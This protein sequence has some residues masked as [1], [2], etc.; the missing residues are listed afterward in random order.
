M[1]GKEELQRASAVG[2]VNILGKAVAAGENSGLKKAFLLISDKS[3]ITG[4][5]ISWLTLAA[6]EAGNG[7]AQEILEGW[8]K[9]LMP[10]W[11]PL[12]KAAVLNCCLARGDREAFWK[13]LDAGLFA[14][15]A[16][17]AGGYEAAEHDIM[18]DG[19][20]FISGAIG[21]CMDWE[22]EENELAG[23]GE[24]Y[25]RRCFEF[26]LDMPGDKS[27]A[28]DFLKSASASCG[29]ECMPALSNLL[30]DLLASRWT[31]SDPGGMAK[32]AALAK[33]RDLRA[34]MAKN[35]KFEK[36]LANGEPAELSANK[37]CFAQ[38]RSAFEL[39][40]VLDRGLPQGAPQAAPGL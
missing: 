38:L 40:E 28:L 2:L 1:A 30:M 22:E 26:A 10:K 9:L 39:R 5:L 16:Q 7:G 6:M 29:A 17:G 14:K 19:S 18:D 24:K 21:E 36:F 25:R 20:L 4:A 3:R 31:L 11:D 35:P 8:D 32:M 13:N 23:L 33:D 37:E 12:D 27:E 15:M 34:W